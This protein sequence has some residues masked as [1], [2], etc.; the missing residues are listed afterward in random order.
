[1]TPSVSA[2]FPSAV[3]LS[4]RIS[5]PRWLRRLS[6]IFPHLLMVALAIGF[7]WGLPHAVKFFVP[8]AKSA[9]WLGQQL[10][11]VLQVS[12]AAALIFAGSGL[13]WLWSRRWQLL[14]GAR[15]GV[16]DAEA[17]TWGDKQTAHLAEAIPPAREAFVLALTGHDTFSH[18]GGPLFDVLSQAQEIRVLLTDPF[19]TAVKQRSETFPP[20]IALSSLQKQVRE[21][22]HYLETLRRAGKRVRL[23]FLVEEPFWKVAII[24]ERAWVQFCHS[25]YDL[26]R[27]PAYVFA[28]K[29]QRPR[30][31]MYVPFYA[32]FID[33]W[34]D[35]D[36]PEYDFK[37]GELVYRDSA[38]A[39]V[40]RVD[41]E[42]HADWKMTQ[43][44][45]LRAHS[46]PLRTL[47]PI[48]AHA[49]SGRPRR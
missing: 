32:Y 48:Q 43:R 7:T 42:R 3:G 24:G 1:M 6:W 45:A 35:V 30:E 26:T 22:I 8:A 28:L 25:S 39:E 21:S 23:K 11:V 38:E 17:Q 31:G 37:T 13:L 15:I 16:V 5:W 2:A 29:P 10:V 4:K 14:G 46:E 9:V 18:E 12:L 20:E 19:S 49:I 40:K 34:N 41:L 36:H 27:E 47:G 44:R 33:Q